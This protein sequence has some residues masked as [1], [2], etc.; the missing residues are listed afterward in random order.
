MIQEAFEENQLPEEKEVICN[1]IS[2][3]CALTEL[4][5]KKRKGYSI[6]DSER[7]S[8]PV[9]CFLYSGDAFAVK[10]VSFFLCIIYQRMKEDISAVKWIP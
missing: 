7:I 10:Q 1:L 2:K 5:R 6:S 3:K 4:D 9:S 8:I